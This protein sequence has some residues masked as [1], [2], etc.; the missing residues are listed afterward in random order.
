MKKLRIAHDPYKLDYLTRNV[1]SFGLSLCI[2]RYLS[3]RF[4]IPNVTN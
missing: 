1:D 2:Y 3:T 4:V